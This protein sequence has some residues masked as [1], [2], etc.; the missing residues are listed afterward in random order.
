MLSKVV[1]TDYLTVNSILHASTTNTNYL[2][3]GILSAS[4]GSFTG[5]NVTTLNASGNITFTTMTGSH[6]SVSSM[7]V[8]STLNISSMNATGNISF[9]TMSGNTLNV[10]SYGNFQT[11]GVHTGTISSLRFSSIT[12]EP[13]I[14]FAAPV[15]FNSSII[16]HNGGTAYKIPLT[17]A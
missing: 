3:T 10:I 13:G 6:I 11:M 14:L 15:S 16:I 17:L 5:L 7:T 2:S 8:H 9:Q 4:T 1:D 12:M